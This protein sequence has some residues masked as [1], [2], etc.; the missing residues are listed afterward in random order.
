MA[1]E[2]KMDEL[3][4]EFTAH[5]MKR[6]AALAQQVRDS[7]ARA[8]DLIEQYARPDFYMWLMHDRMGQQS[9]PCKR[10][11]EAKEILTRLAALKVE[12]QPQ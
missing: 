4:R 5:L 9:D 2:V 6:H 10:A 12:D 1:E 3:T 8:I 7:A 11:V